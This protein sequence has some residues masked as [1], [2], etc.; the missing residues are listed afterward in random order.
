MS[1][2]FIETNNKDE[3]ERPRIFKVNTFEKFADARIT[4][5]RHAVVN[6][7]DIQKLIEVISN[8]WPR[9]NQ[10]DHILTPYYSFR[11]T[12]SHEDDIIIT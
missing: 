10:L 8:R 3:I 9:K 5:I 7:T 11:D 12:L 4:E 2:A 6:D 1:R